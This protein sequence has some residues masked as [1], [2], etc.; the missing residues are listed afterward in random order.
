[1]SDNLKKNLRINH[2]LA[3]KKVA[4]RREVDELIDQ[5]KILVNG[6]YA[7]KGMQVSEEDEI[8]VKN[9]KKYEYFLYNKPKGIVTSSPQKGEIDIQGHLHLDTAIIPV[10]RLDKDSHG[11]ILLTNDKRIVGPLLDP[12]FV[13]EKEY[14]VTVDKKITGSHIEKL[15]AG[16]YI[17]GYKTKPCIVKKID[18][19]TF[20]IILTEGKNRQI[21]KMCA[22]VGLSVIDL[23]RTR[24]MHLKIRDLKNDEK[25]NLTSKEREKLIS[26][27]L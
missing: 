3:L 12:E 15:E 17:D 23:F 26:I 18:T 4:S 5:K 13:H 21:R 7:K 2:F 20:V 6:V 22:K 8:I 19:Y 1:M 11:L 10:G 16:I 14:Q 25:R 27:L 24:I 9:D